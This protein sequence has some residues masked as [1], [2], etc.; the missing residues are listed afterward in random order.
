EVDSVEKESQDIFREFEERIA[1]SIQYAEIHEQTKD[2][3]R[4][5]HHP[6]PEH[7]HNATCWTHFSS[8]TCKMNALQV[9]PDNEEATKG[10]GIGR[11]YITGR[12]SLASGI[13]RGQGPKGRCYTFRSP[14]LGACRSAFPDVGNPNA[15]N[16]DAHRPRTAARCLR[17]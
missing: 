17:S 8:A 14:I 15:Y 5:E 13:A 2:S 1:K 9:R 4:D 7:N 12:F 10:S 3:D 11:N 16:A 6:T